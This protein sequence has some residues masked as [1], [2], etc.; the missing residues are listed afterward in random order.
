[1]GLP[2]VFVI[3]G[4]KRGVAA[5]AADAGSEIAIDG[6]GEDRRCWVLLDSDRDGAA[7]VQPASEDLDIGNHV[8]GLTVWAE[9]FD[10]CSLRTAR[11]WR[12]LLSGRRDGVFNERVGE[13]LHWVTLSTT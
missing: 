5:V 12:L 13:V 2:E 11:E 1:M 10:Q 3:D 8:F 6:A 4:V 7:E 9:H